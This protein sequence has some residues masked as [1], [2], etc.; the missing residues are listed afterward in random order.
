M[1]KWEI[2]ADP[3]VL[4]PL[5]Q[6]SFK[7]YLSWLDGRDLD[8]AGRYWCQLGDDYEQ[9]HG[10]LAEFLQTSGKRK[11]VVLPRGFLKTTIAT[12][13]YAEWRAIRNPN[14]RILIVSNSA[15]NA[16]QKLDFIRKT[17]EQN[18][19]FR[20][21]FGDLKPTDR[22]AKWSSAAVELKR[23]DGWGE[24]TFESVGTGTMI[25]GRHYDL[26]IEDD[27]AAPE[28][29]DYTNEQS[30]APTLESIVKAINWHKK[31]RPL[32][33][34]P[35]LSEMMIVGTRW[36]YYD[37]ISYIYE[38]CK[39]FDVFDKPAIIDG[40]PLYDRCSLSALEEIKAEVG[41]YL[42]QALYLNDPFSAATMAFHPEQI[43]YIKERPDEGFGA[44]TVDSAGYEG[45]GDDTAIVVGWHTPGYIDVLDSVIDR[46]TPENAVTHIFKLC[47]YH[48]ISRVLVE[49]DANQ[50]M[51]E[52]F[53]RD[54]VVRHQQ[55][56]GVEPI[57]TGKRSK[58]MRI[59]GLQPLLQNG[60][61]RFI[62]TPGNK[63]LIDQMLRYIPDMD[64]GHD[65]GPD[66]LANHVPIYRGIRRPVI[67][68]KYD[69]Y[70]YEVKADDIFEHLDKL[71]R[72][73]RFGQ[74]SIVM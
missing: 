47:E 32:L 50:F 10:Q 68:P 53:I 62:K 12:Q 44:I 16:A 64:Q 29:S 27:T 55:S 42:F 69:E 61:V 5:I 23:D 60:Q 73:G 52:K 4:R 18:D 71:R 38:N 72:L 66:A 33:I 7:T 45:K 8:A 26:I 22:R 31:S 56:I 24:A 14:I 67:Q 43:L 25:E 63:K 74:T 40:K 3:D 65:D 30:L 2:T 28:L 20:S 51:Y 19:R 15:T 9:F 57:T 58:S 34:S 13:R 37:L 70:K 46:M 39:D 59:M 49:K 21:V 6:A 11:M 17:F 54:E 41:T 48:N 1:K 35:D 36:T